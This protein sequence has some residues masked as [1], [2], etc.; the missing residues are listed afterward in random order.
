MNELVPSRVSAK[1]DFRALAKQ[2][3]SLAHTEMGQY[4][5][6]LLA[7]QFF[8]H[9][10]LEPGVIISAY[11]PIQD[12]IDPVPL[13]QKLMES[14]HPVALPVV[15]GL[16]AP[17]TFREW[18]HSTELTSSVYDTKIPPGTARALIPDILLIPMLGFDRHGNRLGYGQGYYDH[19]L[20]HLRAEKP[21][22]AVGL[23]YAAQEF[24]QLPADPH[25]QKLDLVI[26]ENEVIQV[27]D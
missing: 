9:F 13:M 19:T 14:G 27:Q 15:H 8:R 11:W 18:K 22:I 10:P 5:G 26:T 6:N 2:K 24:S 1:E 3:R 23:A 4:A 16:D 12:E 7:E 17:L 20:D 21:V 25:D